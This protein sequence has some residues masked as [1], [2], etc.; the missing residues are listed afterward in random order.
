MYHYHYITWSF[1]TKKSQSRP[2]HMTK[3]FQIYPTSIGNG[4][5]VTKTRVGPD[6]LTQ[7]NNPTATIPRFE[8]LSL[9][10]IQDLITSNGFL[11]I[12]LIPPPMNPADSSIDDV[13]A[14]IRTRFA[15]TARMASRADECVENLREANRVLAFRFSK[16]HSLLPSQFSTLLSAPEVDTALTDVRHALKDIYQLTLVGPDL[17]ADPT[18]IAE[19]ASAVTTSSGGN[20]EEQPQLRLGVAHAINL[21][22]RYRIKW[23][24]EV[25]ESLH[26]VLLRHWLDAYT[27]GKADLL[28]TPEDA[29]EV[30][31]VRYS[32]GPSTSYE[33]ELRDATLLHITIK[34][35]LIAAL[36]LAS[37]L[38]RLAF[39]SVMA[40]SLAAQKQTQSQDVLKP[41]D[42]RNDIPIAVNTFLQN[43]Q[44]AFLTLN[45]RNDVLRRRYDTL[46]YDVK[47]VENIVYDL[48]VRAPQETK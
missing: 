9:L 7:K 29:A 30:L 32:A 23:E 28:I 2:R 20:Y 26:F 48:C 8:T 11:L 12:P 21:F 6:L 18:T 37:E 15:F 38:A 34:D 36:S 46:K 3:Q 10:Q 41:T 4:L 33:D 24:A 40:I 42:N 19:S 45:L 13:F 17:P 1:P 47:N 44:A 43:L 14:G 39:T 22:Q 35:Y 27:Q 25:Q 16:L 5:R 31:G